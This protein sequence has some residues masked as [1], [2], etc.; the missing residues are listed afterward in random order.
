M[1]DEWW[2]TGGC[3]EQ[4]PF[5]LSPQQP[6]PSPFKNLLEKLDLGNRQTLRLGNVH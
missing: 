3:H 6:P 4:T 1:T 2:I 5:F